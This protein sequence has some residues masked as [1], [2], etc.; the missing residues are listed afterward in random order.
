MARTVAELAHRDRGAADG[1]RQ[2]CS[3]PS[4]D[5]LEDPVGQFGVIDMAGQVPILQ[6]LEPEPFVL[7]EAQLMAGDQGTL[8]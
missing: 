4:T 1:V 3:I 6:H 2:R 7:H 5:R 8:G